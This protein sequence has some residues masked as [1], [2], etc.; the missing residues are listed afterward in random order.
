[1]R[2][3]I[4]FWWSLIF[5]GGTIAYLVYLLFHGALWVHAVYWV[6][7]LLYFVFVEWHSRK[8]FEEVPRGGARFL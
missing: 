7:A 4:F 5:V 2:H 1:M 3:K 8:T 6:P